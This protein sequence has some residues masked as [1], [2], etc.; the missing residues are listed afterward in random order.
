MQLCYISNQWCRRGAQTT[1][2][3]SFALQPTF[4]QK[5][6]VVVTTV[7]PFEFLP[8]R[9]SIE[10]KARDSCQSQGDPVPEVSELN[11]E[12][13]LDSAPTR[14][15]FPVCPIL[16]SGVLRP[17]LGYEVDFSRSLDSI[18]FW[19]TP[20]LKFYN[21]VSVRLQIHSHPSAYP[22]VLT[23]SCYPGTIVMTLRNTN[24][25]LSKELFMCSI[26]LCRFEE[27]LVSFACLDLRDS[28]ASLD[29]RDS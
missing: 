29:L 17:Q 10:P 20:E 11:Q 26:D 22:S 12:A 28:F 3:P 7:G 16:Q 14:G 1:S 24:R 21:S 8:V 6:A 2:N 18:T 23:H 15:I 9:Y 4:R 27:L 13:I 5:Q 19:N 25:T